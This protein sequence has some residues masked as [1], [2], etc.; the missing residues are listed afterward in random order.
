MPRLNL[1]DI[2]SYVICLFSGWYK[3][4]GEDLWSRLKY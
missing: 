3:T 4:D 1:N 2:E